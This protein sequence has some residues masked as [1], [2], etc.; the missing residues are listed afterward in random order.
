[1]LPRVKRPKPQKA[2]IDG[3]GDW[4]APDSG[5]AGRRGGM[6]A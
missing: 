5:R 1:L 3:S 4:F 2:D 6:A